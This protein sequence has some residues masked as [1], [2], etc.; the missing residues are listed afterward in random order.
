MSLIPTYNHYRKG[1]TFK[2]RQWSNFPFSLENVKVLAEFKT[3]KNGK[4]IFKFDTEDGTF[5]IDSIN[6]TLTWIPRIM[7]YPATNYYYDVQF[8]FLN[9]T[10]ITI[11]ENRMLIF[12]DVTS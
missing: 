9:G 12:Q 3:A 6:G 1:D 7:D 2:G 4:A 8:T 5:A 10:V 11:D